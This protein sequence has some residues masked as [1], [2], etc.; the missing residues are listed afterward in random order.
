[1]ILTP[2]PTLFLMIL[3]ANQK[4]HPIILTHSLILSPTIID[5]SIPPPGAFLIS[6]LR[7]HCDTP[8]NATP[9][10]EPHQEGTPF[11]EKH[12]K[13]MGV[14]RST[15]LK[16]PPNSLSAE[17]LLLHLVAW[18]GGRPLGLGLGV[19]AATLRKPAGHCNSTV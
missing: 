4:F 2:S 19:K 5:N 10:G 1:M 7:S 6:L 14:T 13:A 17:E 8:G 9:V 18:F 3:I 11:R 15:T 12:E 16:E